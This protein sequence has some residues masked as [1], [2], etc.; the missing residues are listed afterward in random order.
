MQDFMIALL[1]CSITM[2]ALALLYMM[3][4]PFLT[5]Y[6][7]EKGRYYAWL[8]IVIGLIIP[9]RPQLGNA[10][11]KVDVPSE[12]A[13]PILQIGNEMP[14]TIPIT[15]PI[16]TAV[17]SPATFSTSWWQIAMEIWL[18][19]VIVFLAYHVIKHYSFVKM[20]RRWSEKIT[21]EE[22]LTLFQ[23]LKAEMGI[24]QRI[25]L[26]LCSYVGSPMMIGFV[27][28]HIFLPSANF[29]QNELLFILKHELVHHKQKDILYKYLVI[30]ATAVHWFNP[31]VYFM[32]KAINEL[33]EVCCDTEVVWSA[34]TDTR[35][36]YSETIIGVVKYRSK[37]KTTLSTHFY[38]GKKGMKNRISSIMDTGQKKAGSVIICMAIVITIG[39]G[40]AF[41]ATT[42]IAE[43]VENPSS[44]YTNVAERENMSKAETSGFAFER[45][46]EAHRSDD[47]VQFDQIQGTSSTE[48]RANFEESKITNQHQ[49]GSG[50]QTVGSKFEISGT[51]NLNYDGNVLLVEITSS[52]FG[53][54]SK[55]QRGG[56]SGTSGIIPIT[57]GTDGLNKWTFTVDATTFKPDEYIV[58]VSGVGVDVADTTTFTVVEARTA[59]SV[60]APPPFTQ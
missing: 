42:N 13:M 26:C 55:E 10:I 14:I 2:S 22:V 5:K 60:P 45:E 40:F 9:F 49:I 27:N 7:S 3:A 33:C 53:P 19:G 31:V 24:T 30:V 56:F 50:E 32:A 41:A 48:Y 25:E 51:T 11:I 1:T 54:T 28:P 57:Q 6:Y 21:D 43:V 17:L 38:G 36:H 4:T 8:V 29:T 47:W 23:N 58:R 46:V 39:T 59:A 15:M 34:D 18:A 12:A 44:V 16:D 20:V 52:S 37:L 35:Q